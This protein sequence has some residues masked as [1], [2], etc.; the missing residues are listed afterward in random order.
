MQGQ[1]RPAGLYIHVPFC[2]RKCAYCAFVSY[3]YRRE[4][5]DCYLDGLLQEIKMLSTVVDRNFSTLYIGG[6]TPTCLP[7]GHLEKIVVSCIDNFTFAT[8]AEITVEA[9]PDTVTPDLL[10]TLLCIGVNRLSIGIQACRSE[11]LATLGR[12]HT[13]SRAQNAVFAARTVGFDNINVDLIFGLPGQSTGEWLK[14]LKCVLALKPEHISAY[15][16]EV[17]QGTPLAGK[18]TSGDLH[19]PGEEEQ[20]EMYFA[21]IDLLAGFG[22]QHYE[23]SN[24]ARPGRCCKH[25]LNYWQNGEYLGLGPA[26]HSYLDGIRRWNLK[27]VTEYTSRLRE[28]LLPAAGQEKISRPLEMAETMFLGLRLTK[29]VS[30]EEFKNRFGL[31]PTKLYKDKIKRLTRD[32]LLE[33]EGIHLKLTPRGLVLANQVFREFLP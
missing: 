2:R 23:I 29:G 30:S 28:G 22:Y 8:D 14:C 21:A 11:D 20:V 25:N 16:L 33:Q 3:P 7:V 17:E 18:I 15:G 24:F 12:I 13:F 9:N 5:A 10:Q 6:G 1:K 27:S 4:E 19:L 26:A 32:G 31:S